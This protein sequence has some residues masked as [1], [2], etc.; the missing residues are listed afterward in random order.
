MPIAQDTRLVLRKGV[1]ARSQAS[2]NLCGTESE[3]QKLS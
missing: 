1:F 2:H 3:Q